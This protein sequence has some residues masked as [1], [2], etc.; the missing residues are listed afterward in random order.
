LTLLQ[1]TTNYNTKFSICRE[2]KHPKVGVRGVSS[3]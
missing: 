2:E 3:L 1:P